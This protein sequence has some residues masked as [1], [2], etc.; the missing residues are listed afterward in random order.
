VKGDR[1]F[2]PTYTGLGERAHLAD[3]SND[4]ETHVRDVVGVLEYE[5]LRD[6]VLIGH[7]YGGMV[8]TGV[9]DC[10][11]DRI[12]HLVYLDAF[13]PK[14]G[15]SLFDLLPPEGRTRMREGA[16]ALGGGWRVP[17]NPTPPDT[18]AVD[19]AWIAPRRQPQPIACFEM[20]LRLQNGELTLPR[21]YI[22]CARAAPGDVFRQFKER[23]ERDGWA[24]Y[25]MDAS[26]SPHV[27]AP[28]A[29]ARLLSDIASKSSSGSPGR[30][31]TP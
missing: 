3:P 10:A 2:T 12:E 4:L 1:L 7:S 28:E 29:L 22:Y 18:S 26:H 25:T 14:D 5:D 17:P 27:T 13:V 9:A 31:E 19:E 30:E 24:C 8:A 15:Q 23:A 11:R 6:V 16:K 20:P 21:S